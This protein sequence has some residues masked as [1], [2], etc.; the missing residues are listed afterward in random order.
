MYV[1]GGTAFFYIRILSENA[2]NQFMG[3]KMNQGVSVERLLVLRIIV[4]FF[5]SSKRNEPKKRSPEKTTTPCLY[6]RYT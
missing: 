5:C 1:G 6:A 4:H 3:I 2:G